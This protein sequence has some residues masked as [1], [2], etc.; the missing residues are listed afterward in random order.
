MNKPVRRALMVVAAL[1]VVIQFIPVKRENLPGTTA[2]TAPADVRALLERSCFDCHSNE[3]VWPW[4]SAV[5]P[6]SWLVAHDVN[7]AREKLNFS[8]WD[9]LPSGERG[10]A[11]FGIREKIESGEM[12]LKQY[13][14]LHP[15]A[16]LDEGDV[17][18]LLRWTG[19]AAGEGGGEDEDHG[20]HHH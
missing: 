12:P 5:A 14:L 7:E 2:L 16:R 4:Y 20:E 6:M 19:P 17:D 10:H 8:S 1:L 18:L 11:F 9:D 3:T 13:L 15:E